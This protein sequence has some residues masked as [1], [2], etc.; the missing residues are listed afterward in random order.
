MGIPQLL[1]KHDIFHDIFGWGMLVGQRSI[2]EIRHVFLRLSVQMIFS[3]TQ[4]R[5][6][7]FLVVYGAKMRDGL[8][9]RD[10]SSDDI[11]EY[12]IIQTQLS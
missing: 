6:A 8:S 11:L 12:T 7:L 3:E 4:T 10:L 5:F 1:M 9:S 2:M